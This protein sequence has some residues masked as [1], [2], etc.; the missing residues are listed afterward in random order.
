MAEDPKPFLKLMSEKRA[1]LNQGHLVRQQIQ[2]HNF[3]SSGK[4]GRVC[5]YPACGSDFAYPLRRFS[6]LCDTFVFCDWSEGGGARFVA[7]I[8]EIKAHRPQRFPDN[9]PDFN[10]YPV[11]EGDVKELANMD[12]FLAKFFPELPS[13]LAGYLANPHSPKGHYAELWITAEHGKPRFLR[14]FWLAMEGVN[15][16][17][18]LFSRKGTAPRILCIKNWGHIGGEWTPFGNWQA[19]LG[20][21]VQT[22]PRKPELL[23]AREG[24]HD[25]PWTLPVGSF[26]DWD[27]LEEKP[28][29]MWRRKNPAS[30]KRQ[31]GKRKNQLSRSKTMKRL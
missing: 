7:A 13:N 29:I 10:H 30:R 4:L 16:Y 18:K 1:A 21:V 28:I 25:W 20:Q 11:D 5:Y 26:K 17:W 9:A 2:A 24:D 31:V 23:V 3:L 6:N 14:V 8:E 19:H 12:H 27:A 15:L 22:G